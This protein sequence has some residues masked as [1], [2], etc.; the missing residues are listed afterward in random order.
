MSRPFHQ[1]GKHNAR[2]RQLL[3]EHGE[4]VILTCSHDVQEFEKFSMLSI[5]SHAKR[6]VESW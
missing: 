1:I 6:Q 3:R 2:L 5:K 4:K